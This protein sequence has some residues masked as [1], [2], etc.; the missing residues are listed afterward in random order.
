MPLPILVSPLTMIKPTTPGIKLKGSSSLLTTVQ[1]YVEKNIKKIISLIIEAWEVSKNIVSFGS[2][3]HT[4][5]EYLQP[6]FKNEEGF[7][8]DVVFPFGIKVSNMIELKRRE[9]D[10]PSPSRIKQLNVCWKEKIKNLRNIVQ[11]C[12]EAIVKKEELFI[13]LTEIDLARSIVEVQD[14]KLI[15]N[16]MFMTRQQFDEHVKIL[17]GLLAKKFN[18]IIEYGEEEIDNWLIDY[19]M[20]Y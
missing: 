18:G 14:P 10:L 12:N 11:T 13:R 20:K 3:A 6:N 9:E 16:S 7:Y 5:H 15:F 17:K 4:F 1:N 19:S 8:T 2:R